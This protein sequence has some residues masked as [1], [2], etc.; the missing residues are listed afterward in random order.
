ML[1]D[2]PSNKHRTELHLQTYD[3]AIP[4]PTQGKQ[5][6]FRAILLSPAEMRSEEDCMG[7]IERLYHQTGGINVGIVFLVQDGGSQESGIRSLM[8][9]QIRYFNQ[10]HQTQ[11]H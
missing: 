11:W 10:N 6:F 8:N 9:L 2:H 7:S 4:L 5:E 3:L 1:P